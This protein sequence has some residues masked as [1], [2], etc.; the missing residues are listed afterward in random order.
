MLLSNSSNSSNS[1]SSEYRTN[2]EMSIKNAKETSMA[3]LKCPRCNSSNTKFC[4]YNNYSLS[5]PRHFCKA[6][7]RYWT[8]GGTLRNV[9]IGGGCRKNKRAKK[10]P[11]HPHP[12][13]SSSSSS[14]VLSRHPPPPPPSSLPMLSSTNMDFNPFAANLP[15]IPTSFLQ[16]PQLDGFNTT[17]GYPSS[18]TAGTNHDQQ[19]FFDPLLGS[20]LSSAAAASLLL[21]SIKQPLMVSCDNMQNCELDGSL[22]L[23][24]LKQVKMEAA[25]HHHHHHHAWVQASCGNPFESMPAN[26]VVDSPST[27]LFWSWNQSLGPWPDTH[28]TNCGSSVAPL[29]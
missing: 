25:D 18:S 17:L 22:G 9:P 16:Q 24:L 7:K 27:N 1:S 28:A 15:P 11:S 21:S 8:R 20:S 29:I 23:A 6:C 12:N 19:Q 10:P 3:A 26:T 4:Y 13:S 2:M 5:Q 14:A